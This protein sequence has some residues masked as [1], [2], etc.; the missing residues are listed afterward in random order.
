M[1]VA[2]GNRSTHSGFAAYRIWLS[3]SGKWR[4]HRG[5][6]APEQPDPKVVPYAT[7]QHLS[8]GNR[9]LLKE[10]LLAN[11]SKWTTDTGSVISYE[12]LRVSK[13][14]RENYYFVDENGQIRRF[15]G[16]SLVELLAGSKTNYMFSLLLED[17]GI[18][19]VGRPSYEVADAEVLTEADLGNLE[20]LKKA[21]LA[22][23]D[24]FLA[25]PETDSAEL[26]VKYDE[27]SI[28][29]FC[30][31]VFYFRD[32]TT[33][34]LRKFRGG[35]L[36]QKVSSNDKAGLV[37][38]LT[39]LGFTVEGLQ[40]QEGFRRL[41]G[42][43]IINNPDLVR[44]II[45]ANSRRLQGRESEE[46][47]IGKIMLDAFRSW[48][49]AE[50]DGEQVG[51]SSDT[52]L[53]AFTKNRGVLGVVECLSKLEIS[54]VGEL[55][56]RQRYRIPNQT[57]RD[58]RLLRRALLPQID[59][60]LRDRDAGLSM[61]NLTSER[62][63]S[64]DL[65]F[66]T[67]EG[68]QTIKCASLI[69]NFGYG[70]GVNGIAELLRH[71]GF[72][73][74][75][76]LSGKSFR[77]LSVSEMRGNMDLVRRII[78]ANRREILAKVETGFVLN[79][80]IAKL[81]VGTF[82]AD[83]DG[84]RVGF[85]GRTFVRHFCDDGSKGVN[86]RKI[87]QSLARV[88]I[89]VG[90]A[91]AEDAEVVSR[92]KE[93]SEL[94]LL[95]LIFG[96]G[97]TREE[98]VRMLDRLFEYTAF[99]WMVAAQVRLIIDLADYQRI[100]FPERVLN[101]G[102]NIGSAFVAWQSYQDR[103]TPLGR[104]IPQ[105]T[106]VD[107]NPLMVQ[108]ARERAGRSVDQV[109]ERDV[110]SIPAAEFAEYDCVSID[111]FRSLPLVERKTLLAR[112]AEGARPGTVLA[113]GENGYGFTDE[114]LAK[115]AGYGF[116][117]VIVTDSVNMSE[118]E[119]TVVRERLGEEA[120]QKVRGINGK[121]EIV[122]A[123]KAERSLVEDRQEFTLEKLSD[124]IEKGASMPRIGWESSDERTSLSGVEIQYSRE[125]LD[126][127]LELRPDIVRLHRT[128]EVL[129]KLAARVLNVDRF[130]R[131]GTTDMTDLLAGFSSFSRQVLGIQRQFDRRA[132][133]EARIVLSQMEIVRAETRD[134]FAQIAS[135]LRERGRQLDRRLH[136]EESL[137]IAPLSDNEVLEYIELGLEADGMANE[138]AVINRVAQ[139]G[140]YETF[141]SE[142]DSVLLAR[143]FPPHVSLV[144]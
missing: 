67:P 22:D 88:G 29:A 99:Y 12:S 123:V 42:K 100:I 49:V 55:A 91:V 66:D 143:G 95:R 125:W 68:R 5:C 34:Q 51:F 72:I 15:Y 126:Q 38:L 2:A 140:P 129:E 50:I 23:R 46:F 124:V 18:E 101:L 36:L 131:A 93:L 132:E 82:V 7:K 44:K 39:S 89:Q 24:V 11:R 25:E 53:R 144:P 52:M 81:F 98:D 10:I 64:I 40:A 76:D 13:F 37:K 120:W 4:S 105:V 60:F 94:E 108:V 65:C 92:E 59:S 110:L 32:S 58:P 127:R 17:L 35:Y 116:D 61:E 115:L 109:I 135:S 70:Y 112:V 138:V 139:R 33:R 48:M 14:V 1:I 19:V 86:V 45:I 54:V 114:C 133:D 117:V 79:N 85:S 90:P 26:T 75:G 118:A 77:R 71:A 28:V 57:L 43:E 130:A 9:Q 142:L 8:L 128:K 74:E 97:F 73:V 16:S 21:I 30:K 103:L 27:I 136:E 78:L 106:D 62:L 56:T 134:W 84:E 141:L 83:I 20:A 31:H 122:I 111:C 121:M 63:P 104:G 80:I 113:I 119:A 107:S 102:S 137:F 47:D 69:S 6:P 3:Q 96:R 41:T 87:I